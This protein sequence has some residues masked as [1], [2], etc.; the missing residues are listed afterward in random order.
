MTGLG[1]LISRRIPTKY[2]QDAVKIIC[3]SYMD[4]D[5][6]GAASKVNPTEQREHIGQAIQ[7][8]P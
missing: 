5:S 1:A 4:V 6:R 8:L 7:A 2:F 3:L